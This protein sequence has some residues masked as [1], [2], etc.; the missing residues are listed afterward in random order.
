[1]YR[2]TVQSGSCSIVNSSVATII[3]NPITVGGS[4]LSSTYVCDSLTSGT[5]ILSGHTGSILNW[6][7]ST[8]AGS[9]WSTIA[10]TTNKQVYAGISSATMFK[11]T[12]QS[13]SCD[14][15]T[16]SPATIALAKPAVASYSFSTKGATSIFTN[17]SISNGGTNLWNFGDNT[18]STITSPAHTYIANGSYSVR[19]IVSDSCGTDS[20]TRTIIIAGLGMNE[21]AYN[22]PNFKIYPNPF[23]SEATIQMNFNISSGATFKMFDIFGKEVKSTNIASGI[24][25]LKLER[26]DLQSGIYFYKLQSL[27][28]ILVTGKVVLE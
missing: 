1:M 16:S 20:I 24:K 15:E 3:V 8:N 19:L 28:E 7:Y 11:A 17:T 13:P 23:S 27:N 12:V 18:I 2:A 14:T 9:S 10:N 5:L 6:K 4:V 21:L 26:E 22:N 25:I